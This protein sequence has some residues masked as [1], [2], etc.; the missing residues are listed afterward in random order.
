MQQTK[1]SVKATDP[2]WFLVARQSH[3]AFVLWNYLIP[4]LWAFA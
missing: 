2:Y 4:S 3:M 1:R